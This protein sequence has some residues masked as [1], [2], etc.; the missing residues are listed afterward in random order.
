[1]KL[2]NILKILKYSKKDSIFIFLITIFLGIRRKLLTFQLYSKPSK[3]KI[4]IIIIFGMQLGIL[5]TR[6]L[7]KKKISELFSNN[8]KLKVFNISLN[9]ANASNTSSLEKLIETLTL[10]LTLT[11]A[12][13]KFII[14]KLNNVNDVLQIKNNDLN[15]A[16]ERALSWEVVARDAWTE[17]AMLDKRNSTF[18]TLPE[19]TENIFEDDFLKLLQVQFEFEKGDINNDNILDY[20]E[21]QELRFD[22]MKTEQENVDKIPDNNQT[23]EEV[24]EEEYP[25]DTPENLD[26]RYQ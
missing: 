24:V 3:L 19:I 4:L 7:L 26:T 6:Q 1:M 2:I 23:L 20:D 13:K 8:E 18:G 14:T 16:Y 11:L 12:L 15:N 5:L 9:K 21:Y 25:G 17:N 22:I 10:T